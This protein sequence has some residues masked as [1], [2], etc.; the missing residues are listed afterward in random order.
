MDNDRMKNDPN[1]GAAKQGAG[2]DDKLRQGG[3]ADQARNKSENATGGT[4]NPP[5]DDR[6]LHNR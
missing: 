1:K 4:R 2:N 3:N 5:R 6:D